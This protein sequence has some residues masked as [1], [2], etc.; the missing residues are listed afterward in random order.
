MTLRALADRLDIEAPA[1]RDTDTGLVFVLNAD[2]L[3]GLRVLLYSMC[4]QRTLLD[5]PILII[6]DQP[7]VLDDPLVALVCDKTRVVTDQ[8]ISQFTGISSEA[9]R[10]E[11]KL[12]WIPAYWYLKWLI[13]DDYGFDRIV[14]IDA[15]IL[16][17]QPID[18]LASMGDADLY[19][20]PVFKS[21]PSCAETTIEFLKGRQRWKNL[22]TG[23]LVVNKS[24]LSA[25]FRRELIRFTEQGKY[26]VEQYALLSFLK[27]SSLGRLELISPT[28]N[29]RQNYLN[30]ASVSDQLKI[31]PQIKLLHFVGSQ[32]PWLKQHGSLGTYLYHR[33]RRELLNMAPEMSSG[34]DG[35]TRTRPD[36]DDDLSRF[37]RKGQWKGGGDETVS[38]S[39]STLRYTGAVRKELPALLA[40]HGVRRLLDAP[41]GDF[42]WMKEVD[43]AGIEYHGMDIV[44]EIV[45]DLEARYAAPTRRFTRGDITADP[46]PHADLMLCRDCL[47]HLPNAY[48]WRFLRNFVQSEIPLLLT[49]SY[50]NDVNE[51]L[52]RPGSRYR[53][54]NL[55][56]PPFSFPAPL[57]ELDDTGATQRRRLL[58]FSN[59]QIRGMLGGAGSSRSAIQ[60]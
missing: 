14:F 4:Q 7:E 43:L 58:L 32:K 28:Y 10:P 37:F 11:L 5:L 21:D 50:M 31:L 30:K 38:G 22:N 1:P 55:L 54:L 39:G 56:A 60:T 40:R 18:D 29:F 25:K 51:D 3:P 23:V 52:E 44:A 36:A 27:E 33:Y 12:E 13:F 17:L 34:E 24:L 48:V 16:C 2:F 15:D 47:I 45:A 26:S 41:C 35:R 46:L 20:G 53:P 9:V 6:T 57:D 42:N 49:T 59:A 19:G 8:D